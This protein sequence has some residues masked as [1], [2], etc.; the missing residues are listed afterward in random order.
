MCSDHDQTPPGMRKSWSF[1]HAVQRH[2][3]C[4]AFLYFRTK[5]QA[6]E[7]EH[8]LDAQF[9][10]GFMD[11]DLLRAIS[12]HVPPGTMDSIAA[13]RPLLCSVGPC[14]IYHIIYMI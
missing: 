6:R 4:G 12:D 14:G 10:F 2:Q 5:L 1:C 3:A 13:F 9:R 8:A 11:A 7:V